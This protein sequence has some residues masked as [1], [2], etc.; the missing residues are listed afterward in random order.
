[1]TLNNS[2]EVANTRSKLAKLEARYEA[3][4]QKPCED[5][6]LRSLTLQSIKRYINQFKEE[7]ARY[8][9]CGPGAGT[10]SSERRGI[11]DD[12]QLE[13]TR[14]KL[15]LLEESLKSKVQSGETTAVA[16]AERSS[17]ER[18]IKQFKEEIVRYEIHQP[19]N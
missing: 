3:L 17:L 12:A 4:L 6:R 7:I 1:V 11:R 18:L 9:C 14:Q 16:Q 13:N 19:A 15:S 2:I 8:E 10:K 5:D